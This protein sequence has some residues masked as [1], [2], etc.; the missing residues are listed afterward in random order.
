VLAKAASLTASRLS[1][2]SRVK[3]RQARGR[4]ITVTFTAPANAAVARVR[5][6]KPGASRSVAAKLVD[7]ETSGVQ[8]VHLRVRGVRAGR[9]R[10]EVATGRGASSLTKAVSQTV[11]LTR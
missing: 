7:I 6:V 5:L 9:Y 1:A 2:A 3:L 10:L 4:G 11:T 8:V